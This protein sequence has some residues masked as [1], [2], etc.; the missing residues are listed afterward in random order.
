[1][2][3][4][5]QTEKDQEYV[6]TITNKGSSARAQASKREK[7]VAQLFFAIVVCNCFDRFSIFSSA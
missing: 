2:L 1:L 4:L 3:Y 6:V 5:F 7:G